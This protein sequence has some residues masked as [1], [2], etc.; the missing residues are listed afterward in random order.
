[1]MM[2]LVA[3]LAI[4]VLIIKHAMRLR[5]DSANDIDLTYDYAEFNSQF[6]MINRPTVLAHVRIPQRVICK[7][8]IHPGQ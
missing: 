5:V 7:I 3:R 2:R 1:M 4:G 6:D 8:I